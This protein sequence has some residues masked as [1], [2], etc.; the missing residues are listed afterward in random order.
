M[1]LHKVAAVVLFFV[2]TVPAFGLRNVEQ[3]SLYDR[4]ARLVQKIVKV[5]VA[6]GNGLIGP[7]PVP[8]PNP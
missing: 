7:L 8:N 5:V 1:R 4:L 3:P 2:L 6:N